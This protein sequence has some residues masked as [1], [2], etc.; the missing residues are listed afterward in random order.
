MSDARPSS[1]HRSDD[2]R[3]QAD[4]AYSDAVALALIDAYDFIAYSP[5]RVAGYLKAHEVIYPVRDARM[6]VEQ[7]L[8]VS[9]V[10]GMARSAHKEYRAATHWLD[11][12]LEDATLLRAQH[13]LAELYHLR[14]S[15][16]RAINEIDEAVADQSGCL[17]VLEDLRDG[18]GSVDPA[19]ELD[20]CIALAGALF[21]LERYAPARRILAAT[22]DL[23]PWT[24]D[25]A[26]RSAS[27]AWMRALV[28]R[29][30]ETPDRA[31][32][33]A[34]AAAAAFEAERSP[35][36]GRPRLILADCALDLADLFPAAGDERCSLLARAQA[37]A[38]RGLELARAA[39]DESGEEVG[40]LA[41]A[42]VDR[43]VGRNVA[44]IPTLESV[45]Y[46]AERLDD[47][48]LVVQAQTAL[49]DQLA[50][51][52]YVPSARNVY[53]AALQTAE[54]SEAPALGIWARRGLARLRDAP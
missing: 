49:G 42:R 40:L 12:A 10:L 48:S 20:A 24:L 34:E 9:F 5:N 35:Q 45:V 53:A 36:A 50:A 25:A 38:Q 1:L 14:G 54:R 3:W 31:L 19:L 33:S 39:G 46:A 17:A 18:S 47:I 4:D 52:G 22:D 7:R 41:V 44:L 30:D 16:H 6:A 51:G 32:V 28:Y 37:A 26:L 29:W 21:M 27:V 23:M 2:P 43:M 8:R 13:A 11:R 15:A